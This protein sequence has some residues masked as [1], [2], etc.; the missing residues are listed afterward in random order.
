MSITE[1]R[2]PK[3]LVPEISAP[4]GLQRVSDMCIEL[5]FHEKHVS[6]LGFAVKPQE[7]FRNTG[8]LALQKQTNN[9]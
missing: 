7:S 4:Y 5:V 1:L 2:C 6:E 3:L 9:R 8:L